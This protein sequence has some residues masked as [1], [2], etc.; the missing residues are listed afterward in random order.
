MLEQDS[1]SI[2]N[3]AIF[4]WNLTPDTQNIQ[5]H[6][7]TTPINKKNYYRIKIRT[8]NSNVSIPFV[9]F[10]FRPWYPKVLG[11]LFAT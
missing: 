8:S 10:F 11:K 4:S 9:L 6:T 7:C 5:N 3:H 1:A 2:L